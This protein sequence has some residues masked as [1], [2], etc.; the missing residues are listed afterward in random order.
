MV[1]LHITDFVRRQ[2]KESEFSHWTITDAE[3]QFRILSKMNSG[4][5]HAGYRKGV[6]LVTLEPEG[7]FS[8]VVTLKEGDTLIGSFRKR[9]DNEEP[10]KQTYI[11]GNKVPAKSVIAVLYSH[12]VLAEKNEQESEANWELVSINAFP[13]EEEAPMSV[14]TLLANHFEFSGGTATKMSDTEF[15]VALRK[16]AEYWKD[17]ALVRPW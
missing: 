9:K 5:C 6:E 10:R 17:K 2:T 13:T 7:F 11:F 3:L 12:A 1:T 16:S 15:I 4:L 8:S 14:G